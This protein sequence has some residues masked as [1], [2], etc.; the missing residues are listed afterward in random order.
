[1][2]EEFKHIDDLFKEKLNNLQAETQKNRWYRIYWKLFWKKWGIL[3]GISAA[4]LLFVSM[5]FWDYLPGTNNDKIESNTVK[6]FKQDQAAGHSDSNGSGIS[7][8]GEIESTN[9]HQETNTSEQVPSSKPVDLTNSEN[10]SGFQSTGLSNMNFTN[11]SNTQAEP[12]KHM[13]SQS[14]YEYQ[15]EIYPMNLTQ[16]GEI[17]ASDNFLISVENS[18]LGRSEWDTVN[19]DFNRKMYAKAFHIGFYL[20]PS[21]ISKSISSADGFADYLK[22]RKDNESNV[23]LTGLGIEFRFSLNK[24]YLQTSL[25]YNVYG[26]NVKYH[27]TTNNIDEQNSHY[28]YDTTW[29]YIYDPPYNGEPRPVSVDSTWLAEYQKIAM[30]SVVKNRIHF[31]EIPVLAGFQ[32]TRGKINFEIGG[33]VS[34]GWFISG[35][36]YLPEHEL[37]SLIPIGKPSP[38]LNKTSFNVIVN[39]GIAWNFNQK[40]SIILKPNYKKNLSSIFTK[41]YPVQQ[42][43]RTF[44]V[45]TGIRIKL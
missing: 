2:V 39:A 13:A 38:F 41:D 14:S 31:I 15:N 40:W 44:G 37:N 11:I 34:F 16:P 5:L 43:Y 30:N 42:K 45:I 22:I 26:E 28:I 36:G 35:K 24:I 8:A 21:Y 23:F 6:Q 25:E 7:S 20:L 9:Q 3:F 18:A 27:F 4:T 32:T 17:A 19:F 33:G 12:E 10:S 1:M 29:I